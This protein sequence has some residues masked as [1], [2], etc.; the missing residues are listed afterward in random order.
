MS[1]WL[2]GIG[3]G[4]IVGMT[5]LLFFAILIGIGEIISFFERMER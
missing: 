4:L 3:F 2:Y 5:V 1:E